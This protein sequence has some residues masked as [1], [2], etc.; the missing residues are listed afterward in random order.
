MRGWAKYK[1]AIENVEFCKIEKLLKKS[2]GDSISISSFIFDS[3]PLL[4][5]KGNI[6]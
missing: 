1:Y 6:L 4:K 2:R 5:N 3:H